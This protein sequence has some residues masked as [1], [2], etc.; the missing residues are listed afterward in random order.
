M[1]F[2]N[3]QDNNVSWRPWGVNWRRPNLENRYKGLYIKKYIYDESERM[4]NTYC[5]SY[6]LDGRCNHYV[7]TNLIYDT[8]SDNLSKLLYYLDT[9]LDILDDSMRWEL[10]PLRKTYKNVGDMTKSIRCELESLLS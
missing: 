2:S 8:Y 4:F 7:L 9:L 6:G 5:K 10:K 3:K 1:A